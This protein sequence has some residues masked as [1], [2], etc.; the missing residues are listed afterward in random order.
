VDLRPLRETQ[1]NMRVFY[2]TEFANLDDMATCELI[3]AGFVTEYGEEWYVEISDFL[4]E[5]CSGFVKE[6]VLPLLRKGN[7]VPDIMP[8]CHFAWRLCN[9]L[10]KLTQ[11]I[12]LVSDHSADWFLINDYCES[13]F[14]TFT[15]PIKG[16]VWQRSNEIKVQQALLKVE[17]DFWEANPGMQHHALYDARRLRLNVQTQDALISAK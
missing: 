4:V 7:K 9:W 2:D 11:P 1:N 3:S 16:V 12:E 15:S 13:E 5:R 6:S 14:S 8:S 17:F 10:E